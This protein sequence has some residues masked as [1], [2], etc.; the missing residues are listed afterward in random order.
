MVLLI[1]E[2]NYLPVDKV[3]YG[4]GSVS[5]IN[6]VITQ[7]K[8]KNALILTSKS[9]SE[10]GAF[11]SLLGTLGIHYSIMN[12]ITQHSPMEEIEHATEL[13]RNCGCDGIISVGGGSVTDAAKVLKY[14][15]DIKITHIAIPTT[16]SASEFSHIAGYS[17]GGEKEGIRDKN[18]TPNIVVL[19][20]DFTGETPEGLWRSTGI[21][22][23]DH[24]IETIIQPDVLDISRIAAL[25]SIRILFNNLSATNPESRLECQIASW[26]SYFQVF[27][28]PMGISH[29]L[30]KIIGAKYGIPHGITSCIT[31]PKVMEFYAKIYPDDMSRIAAAITGNSPQKEDPENAAFL[32][33][34][35][36]QSLGLNKTLR[37]YNVTEKDID[38][39]LSRIKKPEDWY[40][41]LLVQLVNEN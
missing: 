30:G 22:S 16:L 28:S 7:R 10:T 36:I 11:R 29:N 20:P 4:K 18:I 27:D 39:I 3:I 33:K 14:Y 25:E 26:Y 17:I 5:R 38:Y 12:E 19:D 1:R 6:P 40:R 21:R 24:A 41:D 15:Y 35:F 34:T 2:F 8:M 31:L 13:F 37:D 32:V 9:V 23:L